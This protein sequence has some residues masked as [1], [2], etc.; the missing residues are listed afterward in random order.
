MTAL[1][2]GDRIKFIAA[3]RVLI[4]LGAPLTT[5]WRTLVAPLMDYGEL[6]LA[7]EAMAQY[8][9]A[10]GHAP[11]ALFEQAVNFAQTAQPELA[12]ANLG[13]LPGD[14]P[15]RAGNAYLRGTLALNLGDFDAAEAALLAA[16]DA[17]PGSG[18]V[19][20]TLSSIGSMR[21]RVAAAERILAAE[22]SMA[23]APA[24]ERRPYLYALGKTL[25]DL[26]EPARAYAAYAAGAALI[27]G[28][29][30]YDDAADRQAAVRATLG[31]SRETVGAVAGSIATPTHLP[32]RVTGLPRSGSTLVEQILV[33]HSAIGDGDELMRFGIVVRDIGG[34]DHPTL[35][36]WLRTRG[37]DA[38]VDL[39]LHLA[40][41]RFG[42]GRR[43]VDKTLDGSRQLGLYAALL[44]RTPLI[45]MR[46]DPLDNAWSC[47]R[48]YFAVGLAWSWTQETIAAHFRLEDALLARWRDILGDRLLVLDY[49]QLV[50]NPATAIPQLLAHCGL[51]VEPQ[52]F[53]PE[54]T[55]RLVT[56]NSVAQVR[57]PI[58][59]GAVESAAPYRAYLQPFI[60]SYRALGGAID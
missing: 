36:R 44:P 12:L 18:Q 53:A 22:R 3:V 33:S 55:R 42:A 32:I 47:L 30:P 10:S 28:S 31:W 7:R 5:G 15:D 58:N 13:K 27:A 19:W 24:T 34:A 52:V 20:Q 54:R 9:R 50:G 48:T 39:Y 23:D 37:P 41:E 11:A 16:A 51:P 29:R 45:W 2:R 14:V 26:D 49:E 6:G 21:T 38:A 1:Q 46:R 8:V 57:K 43:F 40:A 59:R 35:A 17:R 60:D 4:D 25:A 56:T